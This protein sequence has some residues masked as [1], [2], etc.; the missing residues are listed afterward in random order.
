MI[1]Y[2][3]WLRPCV[4]A[5][6]LAW[7]A[8]AGA[9]TLGYSTGTYTSPE[10]GIFLGH[11]N[12]VTTQER[13][14]G[15]VATS[16]GFQPG[17]RAYASAD[18]GVLKAQSRLGF[19]LQSA[20]NTQAQV[21][22]SADFTAHVIINAG[23]PGQAGVASFVLNFDGVFNNRIPG[24]SDYANYQIEND[25]VV[26]TNGSGPCNAAHG[27]CAIF[28]A[29]GYGQGLTQQIDSSFVYTTSFISGQV[30]DI[31]VQLEAGVFARGG[32]TGYV[33]SDSDFSHTLRWGGLTS[34]VVG[35]QDVTNNVTIMSDSGFDFVQAMSGAVPEPA[36]WAILLTGFGV[37][38]SAARRRRVVLAS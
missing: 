19:Q 6:A 22:S 26:R 9:V 33:F 34:A 21:V 12:A 29:T 31:Y 20:G 15:P 4:A 2:H 32:G 7:G 8:S 13:D 10:G 14:Y 38:G 30:T 35:G 16:Q 25:I 5:L 36:S 23:T 24:F 28:G 18:I 3:S 37:L 27:Y 11:D 1:R 17:F